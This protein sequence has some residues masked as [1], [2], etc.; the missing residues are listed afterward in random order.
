MG[1]DDV[2][3]HVGTFG[4]YQCRIF[5]I[6]LLTTVATALHKIG[7]VFLGIEVDFRCLLP[8]ESLETADFHLPPNITNLTYLWNEE[9][10]KWPQCELHYPNFG[11]AHNT[12]GGNLTSTIKCDSFVY[13]E[14]SGIQSITTEVSEIAHLKTC[15]Y[16]HVR[17]Y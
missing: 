15:F 16:I 12:T 10:G 14:T 4:R 8:Y 3:P 17:F 5:A 7:G 6:L 11:D 1:Y 9:T 2:L 13:D